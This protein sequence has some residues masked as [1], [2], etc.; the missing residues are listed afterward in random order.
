MKLKHPSALDVFKPE[1][2]HHLRFPKRKFIIAYIRAVACKGFLEYLVRVICVR[3][4][5]T[6]IVVHSVVGGF[7]SEFIKSVK[8]DGICTAKAVI[9]AYFNA[10]AFPELVNI[11]GNSMSLNVQSFIGTEGRKHLNLKARLL[12]LPMIMEV[13]GGIVGRTNEQNI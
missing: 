1:E 3:L 9:I 8:R 10:C 11:F 13:I 4:A 12:Y 6:N 2:S 7:A 5:K